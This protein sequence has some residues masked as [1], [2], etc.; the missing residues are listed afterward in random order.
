MTIKV[1]IADDQALVRTGFRKILESEPDLEVV[2]EAGDGP[3][4]LHLARALRPDVVLLDL[5]LP[6]M[7][8]I[9]TTRILRAAVPASRVVAVSVREDVSTR[10]AAA[11]AGAAAFV[12]KQ[13]GPDRLLATI[14]DAA[15][16]HPSPGIAAE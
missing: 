7:D 9:Q 14:R 8:G 5:L 13:Q 6:G 1:L 15:G 10:R 2:G 4:A 11:A 16:R 12:G 3:A